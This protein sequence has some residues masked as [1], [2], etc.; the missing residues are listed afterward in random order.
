ME[1]RL[2][3][4]LGAC[5]FE[6]MFCCTRGCIVVHVDVFTFRLAW[7]YHWVFTFIYKRYVAPV[8]LDEYIPGFT[9]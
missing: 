3:L 6:W 5:A 9:P 2:L 4:I 7:L 8:L 1:R